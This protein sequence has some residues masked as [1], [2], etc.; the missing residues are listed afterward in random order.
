MTRRKTLSLL[1]VCAVVG[2]LSLTSNASASSAGSGSIEGAVTAEG[3]APLAQAWVCAYRV[4]GESFEQRCVQTDGDGHYAL[5]GLAGGRYKVEFWSEATGPSYVGEYYDDKV[6]WEEADEVEVQEGT[7]ATGIDAELA[8]GAIV[9]GEV[10]AASLGGPVKEAVACAASV[11]GMGLAGCAETESDGT[12]LLPGLPTGEYKIIFFPNSSQYNLL[13]QYYDHE[14][15]FALADPISVSGGETWAGIDADL[16]PGAE[17]QGTVYSAASGS[18]LSKITVCAFFFEGS[19]EQWLPLTCTAT[20]GNGKYSFMALRS[21]AY[22]VSFSVD[23]NEIF[24]VGRHE[25]D[26]YFAQ[27]FDH[28]PTLA[29]ADSLALNA[30]EVR[31]GVDGYLQPKFGVSSPS[32]PPSAPVLVSMRPH[33]KPQHCRPGFRRRQI[34][35][36]RRCVKIH[37]HRRRHHGHHK[38]A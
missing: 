9:E 5:K 35:G 17:I 27:Y 1:L 4:D 26:G 22:R 20:T 7:A 25:E 23:Q 19:E 12:Y 38:V 15:S 14:P 37:K 21:E 10:R 28:S 32:S 33:R 29:A 6:S 24:G 18:P 31:N 13:D 11:T 34:A 2:C 3:G 36:K 16:E 8:E 30:P